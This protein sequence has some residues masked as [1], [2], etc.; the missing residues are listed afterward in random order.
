MNDLYMRYMNIQEVLSYFS[1]L[2]LQFGLRDCNLFF[3]VY[4]D[5]SYND[6]KWIFI[7]KLFNPND[8]ITEK[9]FQIEPSDSW[10]FRKLYHVL[11]R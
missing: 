4:I 11:F 1:S 5:M 2:V 10:E 6:L 3:T 9:R 7:S 8:I